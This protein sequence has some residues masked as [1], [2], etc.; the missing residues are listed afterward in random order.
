LYV[1]PKQP[2]C[3]CRR[4]L[5]C[6]VQGG[7][8]PAVTLQ[9]VPP[10][11]RVDCDRDKFPCFYDHSPNIVNLKDGLAK[12]IARS[13]DK[14]KDYGDGFKE[15]IAA[16]RAL[17]FKM[18]GTL[19][20]VHTV[21]AVKWGFGYATLTTITLAYALIKS[22]VWQNTKKK[23]KKMWT[24]EYPVYREY[25]RFKKDDE[26]A[27]QFNYNFPFVANNPLLRTVR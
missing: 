23:L 17:T 1:R 27:R 9:C 10:H 15:Y 18:A 21:I 5:D 22:K 3:F 14:E 7:T 20:L 2:L 25:W 16:L 24:E 11:T 8:P 19:I 26:I 4:V 6:H 13:A 12:P